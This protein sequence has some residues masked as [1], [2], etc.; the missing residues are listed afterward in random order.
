M[1]RATYASNGSMPT[2]ARSA[3]IRSGSAQGHGTGEP[4]S[5][6]PAIWVP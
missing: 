2:A 4:S 1:N 6:I 5:R 3:S